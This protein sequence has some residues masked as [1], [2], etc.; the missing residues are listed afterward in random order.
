MRFKDADKIH[1]AV[2]SMR[3]AN[4]PVARNRAKVND[5]FNGN[6]PWSEE[7]R[8]KN[9]VFSNANPLYGTRIAHSAAQ[10]LDNA[11]LKPGNF[12]D[13]KLDSGPIHKRMEWG[14]IITKEVNRIL[15]RQQLFDDMWRATNK[16]VVLHGL[17]PVWWRGREN[18]IPMEI[19]IEDVLVPAQTLLNFSNLEF[20]AV[21]RQW[22]YAEL[23]DMT[24]RRQERDPGW[25]MPL[26]DKLLASLAEQPLQ[27]TV[28]GQ[29]WLFPEKL[30]EDLKENAGLFMTSASP[31]IFIWDFYFRD[32][33][34]DKDEQ[35]WERRIVLD[36]MQLQP[37]ALRS[38]ISTDAK[39]QFLYERKDTYATDVE[40]I[41]H[42]QVGNCSPVAPSRYYSVRSLGF[43]LFAVCQIQNR[44]Y[45]RFADSTFANM[46]ELFRNVGEDDRER[47]EKVDLW[48]MGIVP[49]G[50]SF[51]T[52]D[53]RH[54]INQPQVEM[55]MALNKQLMGESSS[56]W[57]P[58]IDT[59]TDKE[60]T[61]GEAQIR[62]QT[63]ASLSAA[64]QNQ[65]Y[66]RATHL[67][68]ESCRRFCASGTKNRLAKE[69]QQ[70]VM[71]QGVPEQVLDVERWDIAPDRVLGGGNKALEGLAVDK[72]MMA[73]G[74]FD[75]DSQ[76]KILWK[77]TLAWTD[78]ADDAN[79][80]V[81]MDQKPIGNGTQLATLAMGTLMEGLPVQQKPGYNEL[82]YVGTL[83][84][85]SGQALQAVEASEQVPQSLPIRMSKIAGLDNTLEHIDEHLKVLAGDP[86]AEQ[87][88]KEFQKALAE[89]QNTLQKL[90]QHV[91][92]ELQQSGQQAQDGEMAKTQAKIQA[93]LMEAESRVKAKDAD[94]AQKQEHKDAQWA[95]ENARKNAMNEAEIERKRTQTAV[96]V[97]TKLA[98]TKADIAA[99]DLTTAAEIR[100][101][102]PA[103]ASNGKK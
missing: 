25:N 28:M 20:F 62:L 13:V 67:Y 10:N 7:E 16:Q 12:F 93:M 65:Q 43:L 83:L 52:A 76:R 36:Y 5:L 56:T 30:A 61:L 59:G 103:P 11:V 72:L 8:V 18:P 63:S 6:P 98:Q 33:D 48:H 77:A 44:A 24:K 1:T 26:V 14:A 9:K 68:K 38:A 87:P 22:T 42:W 46:L 4:Y 96:D 55:F 74:A 51:V 69:F 86:S 75:P 54:E 73:R 97:Q 99:K 70:R 37:E 17:G 57:M 23:W 88:A 29:R 21:Y 19:G 82:D 64:L 31:T 45:N 3:L 41:I 27:S 80:L 47:L 15:K 85:L 92:E 39:T 90:A 60:Q 2:E 84:A 71:A 49:D 66:S 94:H 34:E 32:Y 35:C 101:P 53:E 100:R 91:E 102:K 79:E 58:E 81:P 40:Q 50:L 89:Q 78:N 95:N